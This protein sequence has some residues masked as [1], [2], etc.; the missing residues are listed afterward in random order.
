MKNILVFLKF[1]LA[2]EKKNDS[3]DFSYS[4]KDFIKEY[5]GL[6]YT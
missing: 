3:S 4:H 6:Q 2:L 5:M 1:H